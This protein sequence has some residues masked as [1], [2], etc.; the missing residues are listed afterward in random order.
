TIDG[1]ERPFLLVREASALGDDDPCHDDAECLAA[2]SLRCVPAEGRCSD[3]PLAG[4]A[5]AAPRD[6]GAPD[7][8][9]SRTDAEAPRDDAGSPVT[10][11]GG[12]S[13]RT[14]GRR[15]ASSALALPL[16][17][18]VALRRRRSRR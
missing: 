12:C 5:G 11:D 17:A 14:S 7:A 9:S 8:G 18:L 10:A 2:G 16:F 13:C 1:A 4:D 3:E 6:G 15:R